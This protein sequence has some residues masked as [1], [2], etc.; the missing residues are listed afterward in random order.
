MIILAGTDYIC[1]LYEDNNILTAADKNIKNIS[2]TEGRVDRVDR[3]VACWVGVDRCVGRVGRCAGRVGRCV[4][5]VLAVD[6][7]R[8]CVE[9]SAGW[10]SVICA[11]VRCQT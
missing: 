11:Q 8:S 4:G 9:V 6:S 2:H 10:G 3:R 7:F 1:F 5:V